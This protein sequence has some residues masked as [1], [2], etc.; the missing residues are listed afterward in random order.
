MMSDFD[1]NQPSTSKSNERP[2]LFDTFNHNDDGT[3][4]EPDID[5]AS[6]VSD[7]D[8]DTDVSDSDVESTHSTD[9]AG[10]FKV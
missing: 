4:S 3:G 8:D 2:G 1:P 5:M 6:D 9:S 10:T 7:F